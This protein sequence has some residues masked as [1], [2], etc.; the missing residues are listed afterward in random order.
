[1]QLS[2]K[3]ENSLENINTTLRKY[4]I[5]GWKLNVNAV[6]DGDFSCPLK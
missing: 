3:N 4:I 1:M 5:E 6:A 2:N